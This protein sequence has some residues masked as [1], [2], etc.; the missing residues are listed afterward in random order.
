MDNQNL[1]LGF[2][3]LKIN[4]IVFSTLKNLLMQDFDE[5]WN[6]KPAVEI[7]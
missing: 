4:N 7:H 1:S 5:H 2:K 3:E 6:I